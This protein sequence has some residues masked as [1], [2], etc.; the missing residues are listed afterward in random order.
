MV[1]SLKKANLLIKEIASEN[2]FFSPITLS[3]LPLFNK[4]FKKEPHTYGNSWTYVTQG[5][6]GLGAN[7]LGYKYYDGK[8]LAAV[9][10]Y[11]K[12]DQPEINVFYWVRP[13]GPKILDI[14]SLSAKNLLKKK[15]IPTYVKKIFKKQYQYLLKKGFKS[16]KSF[17]WHSTCPSEDD[18]YPELIFDVQKTLS[19]LS[20]PPR[21]SNIRKSYRKA[22]SIEKKNK[23]VIND[24]NFN[25]KAWKITK[26]FFSSEFIKKKKTNVSNEYDYY[27]PI[28]NNNQRKSLIKNIFYVNDVPLGY[29]IAEKQNR[30]YTSIY[31]LIVL[32]DKIQYLTDYALFTLLKNCPTKYINIGGSEDEGIHNF[33]KKF[34]PSFQIEMCWATYYIRSA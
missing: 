32:R 20:A 25:R 33:K 13:M 6:Y 28:F 3:D 23:V 12:I 27:N 9:A 14:I 18:T 4:F 29:Y 34:K 19:L 26:S 2:S 31:A 5:M 1:L 8:N 21:T 11:P 16:T 15:G 17:P 10:V 7:N 22:V 30:L 24:V